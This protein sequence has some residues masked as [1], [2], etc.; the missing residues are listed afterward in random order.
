MSQ[1]LLR[2]AFPLISTH[3]FTRKTL[4]LSSPNAPLSET[5]VSA[6]F[7]KGDE[8]PRTLIRAWMEEGRR[9]MCV[10]DGRVISS[11]GHRATGSGTG[12]SAS[13]THDALMMEDV[14]LKR[15][16]W[17]VPVL[18]HLKDAFAL[19]STSPTP[20][21]PLPDVRP[22]LQHAMAVA[23]EACHLCAPR[24]DGPSGWYTRR[25]GIALI[26]TA[27][28][29]HQLASPETAPS[30]LRRLLETSV[31]PADA[32]NELALYADFSI[33]AWGGILRGRGFY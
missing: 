14:L 9:Q 28:E 4:A 7:G 10:M 5:A 13:T 23:D 24:P 29:L 16:D 18:P 31:K 15:L 19:L 17:N 22:G 6:L 26:Y 11:D 20:F 27:A 25:A 8:A 32:M 33:R 2:R 3:G 21:V 12:A 1:A 30:F